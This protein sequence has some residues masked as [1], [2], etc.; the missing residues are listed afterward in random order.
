MASE[1]PTVNS[2]MQE[3]DNQ[4]SVPKFMIASDTHS[5][6]IDDSEAQ[7]P[8]EVIPKSMTSESP[9]PIEPGVESQCVQPNGTLTGPETYNSTGDEVT[10]KSVKAADN[11]RPII[12]TGFGPISRYGDTNVS[13]DVVQEFY[14]L[15]N[16]DGCL[17]YN[18]ECI[19]V[20][21][22]TP[23]MMKDHNHLQ[24]IETSYKFVTCD[25]PKD[26]DH[27]D[28][29][30]PWLKLTNARLCVHLGTSEDLDG[31]SEIWF[32]LRA[33][34]GG[35]GYWS[36]DDYGTLYGKECIPG[37]C[38]YLQTSFDIPTLIEKINKNLPQTA[39]TDDANLS[40][41]PSTKAGHFLC[42]FLYYRSL[43]YAKLRNSSAQNVI[44]IHIPPQLPDGVIPKDVALVLKQVVFC[45][46]DMCSCELNTMPFANGIENGHERLTNGVQDRDEESYTCSGAL[47]P[48]NGYHKQALSSHNQPACQENPGDTHEIIS[49]PLNGTT[50]IEN[51]IVIT[52][53][54]PIYGKISNQSWKIVQKFCSQFQ[55]KDGN[56]EHNSVPLR[57]M[58][59][60]QDQQNQPITTTYA[61][62]TNDD[63]DNWLRSSNALLYIH[64]GVNS[65]LNDK[66]ENVFSFEKVAVNG[67]AGYW[68]VDKCNQA[69]PG[70]CVEG[71]EDHLFTQFSD[72]Q[73]DELISSLPDKV[74][75]EKINGKFT[76]KQS[77]EA[78]NFLCDFLYYRSL[79]YASLRN[80]DSL[81]GQ[82]SY[83]IFIHVPS[84]LKPT[85]LAGV[86]PMALVLNVIVQSLLDIITPSY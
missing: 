85:N 33:C 53:F 80:E 70:P 86:V 27:P 45:L 44:F 51:A 83:V 71:G 66:S 20:Q 26:Q 57:L 24:P 41:K 37:G 82:K 69:F 72:E 12:V 73:L 43:Y 1:S 64:L 30:D 28:P 68:N 35:L 34:N 59:G 46:L 18:S 4:G 39:I 14:W 75:N 13:K 40:F 63:V 8:Q 67:R 11:V 36:V 15:L 2:I 10:P 52:G 48:Q 9:T 7:S 29:F 56:I 42:N 78:G 79:Y 32:E 5:S 47:V 22:G 81:D 61:G 19:P 84:E 74:K 60:P 38:E 31:S 58:T 62:V 49:R 16:S 6:T 76:F 65:E 23:D 3:T 21:T 17:V 54:D 50:I 55:Q 77:T 25:S